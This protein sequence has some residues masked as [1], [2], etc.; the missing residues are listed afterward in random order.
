MKH[1]VLR[2]LGSTLLGFG[3]AVGIGYAARELGIVPKGQTWAEGH[4]LLLLRVLYP[5]CLFIG[6]CIGG[7][8]S[9]LP[10]R[11]GV[12]LFLVANPGLYAILGLLI[13]YGGS[14]HWPR[15]MIPA[16]LIWYVVAYI[17]LLVGVCLRRLTGLFGTGARA[18]STEAEA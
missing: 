5:S 17:G 13:F 8:L 7:V 11:R 2:T 6:G 4:I 9:D 12:L 10:F 14:M 15:F 16:G 3:V 18:Q 1:W